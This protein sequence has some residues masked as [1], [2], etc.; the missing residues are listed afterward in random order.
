MVAL[1]AGAALYYLQVYAFYDE[2]KQDS[3]VIELT[4]IV[5]GVPEEIIADGFEGIDSG[6]SPIRFRGC[7][8]TPMSQSLLS[9][10]YVSYDAAVPLIGPSWFS[11]FDAKLIGADL[12][13]GDALPF[14][15]QADIS[16]GVDRVVAVYPD[17]RAYIW[18]QLNDKFAE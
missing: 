7:F 4:S 3:T 6:S 15:S 14:L 1:I 10:T 16:N 13:N 9:E 5:S 11:C 12:E 18:H 8:T 17:G 2:I